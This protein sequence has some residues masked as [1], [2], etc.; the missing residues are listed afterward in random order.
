MNFLKINVLVSVMVLSFNVNADV[1]KLSETSSDLVLMVSQSH[2]LGQNDT[3][4]GAN[5][6]NLEKIKVE[7]AEYAGSVVESELVVSDNKITKQQVKVLAAGYVEVLN[8]DHKRVINSSGDV[9]LTTHAKVKLAKQAIQ[10]GLNKLKVD[11]VRLKRIK[12]LEKKNEQLHQ[13]LKNLVWLT[14]QETVRPD[15]LAERERI[16][17]SLESNRNSTK[18]LFTQG[19]V[20]HIAKATDQQYDW[21]KKEIDLHVLNAIKYNTSIALKDVNVVEDGNGKYT[22]EIPISWSVDIEPVKKK[23]HEYFS[24]KDFGRSHT[25]NTLKLLLNK[26]SS[27]LYARK[28]KEYLFSHQILIEVD[29]GLTKYYPAIAN[30]PEEYRQIKTYKEIGKASG[31]GFDGKYYDIQ[32]KPSRSERLTITH[33]TEDDLSK[34]TEIKSRVVVLDE[35]NKVYL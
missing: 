15:I 12:E 35:S 9:V 8:T 17:K 5:K 16:L 34:I 29:L 22:L 28:L 33:L 18:K 24:K 10:D 21:D 4:S 31:S 30:I 11:S 23:L 1:T 20:L 13:K 3:L 14:N 19:S 26:S 32:Y 2:T 6:Y 7:A 27:S 25:P